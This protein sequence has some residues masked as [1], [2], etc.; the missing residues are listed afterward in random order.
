MG[1][2]RVRTRRKSALSSSSPR[3]NSVHQVSLRS[4]QRVG[5]FIDYHDTG[6]RRLRPAHGSFVATRARHHHSG[7]MSY[8]IFAAIE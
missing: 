2:V 7:E 6:L 3:P 5:L 1:G 8:R 4:P